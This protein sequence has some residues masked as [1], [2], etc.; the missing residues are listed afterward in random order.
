MQRVIQ[1]FRKF[2][3]DTSGVMIV[4]AVIIL[5]VLA[6]TFIAFSVIW[7]AY[8]VK[9]LAQKGTFAVADI[10]SR[11]RALV[12]QNFA[13]SYAKVFAYAAEVPGNLTLLN[14]T[15]GP[16]VVRVTSVGFTEGANPG[17]EG[18]MSR[19]WSMS[20]D[21]ARMPIHTATSLATIKDKIPAMLDGDNIVVVE[22]LLKWQPKF[23][24][25]MAASL[26]GGRAQ[27]WLSNRNIETF[28]TVRPRFVPKVCFQATGMNVPCEL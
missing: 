25:T 10:I 16:V 13:R 14:L 15:G 20:S 12:T 2:K 27:T 23:T 24:A 11:E 9:N 22:T 1:A 5:P 19:M 28:T 21:A 26:M 6:W 18:V 8:R 17:D 4:E 7:D 3:S